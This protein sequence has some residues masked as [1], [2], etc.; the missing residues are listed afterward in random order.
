MV[1]DHEGGGQE[2]DFDD[3]NH[4]ANHMATAAM[5]SKYVPVINDSWTATRNSDLL[6]NEL[7]MNM[8]FGRYGY[9]A[10]FLFYAKTM[11]TS[12]LGVY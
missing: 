3:V 6:A 11:P 4:V 12:C 7:L 10:W 8:W 1:D 2:Y 5:T 9:V